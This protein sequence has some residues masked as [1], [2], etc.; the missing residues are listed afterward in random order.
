MNYTASDYQQLFTDAGY[1]QGYVQSSTQYSN[2][3]PPNVPTYCIY[4][5]GIP[6]PETFVYDE[7]FPDTQPSILFGDGDG[8]VNKQS[9]E[10]CALWANS[11]YP[12][13]RTVFPGLTHFTITTD[14]TVLR[15]IGEVVGA[16]ADP[17]NG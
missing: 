15:I 2:F 17:I 9:L 3:V 13:N 14:L 12:F 6:T 11:S 16:P 4:G 10:V 8:V 5:L 1:P 7:G